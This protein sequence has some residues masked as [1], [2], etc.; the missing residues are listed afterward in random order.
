MLK[1]GDRKV[2]SILNCLTKRHL[3]NKK[4]VPSAKRT[5]PGGRDDQHQ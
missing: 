4:E 2:H 5:T 1:D 3:N